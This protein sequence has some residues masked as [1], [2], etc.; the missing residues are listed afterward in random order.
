MAL[1]KK[2]AA[3]LEQVQE[4]IDCYSFAISLRQI[5]YQLVVRQFIAN[6]E[7][8]YHRV[9][10]LCV[11][12]RDEGI[13]D[14]EAFADRLRQPDKPSDWKDLPDFI[15]TVKSAYRKNK[16]QNQHDYVEIW[17]EKDALREVITEITHQ[18]GVNLLVVRGQVSRTA[19]YEAH[20]RFSEKL[21]D[22]KN[23]YLYYMG[24]FDPSGLS[25]YNSLKERLGNFG[26]AG[27]SIN[28]ERIA[29]TPEQIATYHL[30]HDPAKQT[31][32]NYKK[33]VAEYGDNAVELDAL[34]PDVLRNL[35][36]ENIEQH[37]DNDILLQVQKI[38]QEEKTQ[39]Q[40]FIN[41]LEL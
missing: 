32:P 34:P 5:F 25:I 14:E 11:I 35:I 8:Q 18:Y 30:P 10:R 17:T 15:D 28:F 13:L 38:E 33:F 21:D 39:L 36:R 41:Q 29:L 26:A 22:G 9:S 2:S 40:G 31:D 16:W 23:L 3:L 6:C 37:I 20:E 1:Q 7:A 24:D 4:I 27:D 19:I 12:G